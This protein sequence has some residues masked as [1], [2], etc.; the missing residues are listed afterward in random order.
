MD[1]IFT[2]S[3]YRAFIKDAIEEKRSRNPGFSYRCAAN[4]IGISSGSLTRVLNGSRHAGTALL[5]KL[6]PFLGLKKRE[7][8]YFS[9]LVQFES[10]KEETARRLCY[11]EILK[12][13]AERNKPVPDENH[14]FFEQWYHVALF[15]LLRTI[16]DP[17]DY[18]K[19]GSLLQPA[20]SESKTRK[21]LELLE[22]LGYIKKS[23][24]AVM[25]T[26]EP[27]LTTGD[28]WESVAIHGFQVAISELAASALDTVPK[29]ERDFS[30][31]TMA[32]SEDAFTKIRQILQRARSEIAAV[33]KTCTDPERVYQINFQCFPLS[34]KKDHGNESRHADE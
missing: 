17:V 21:A 2:Y 6:I 26:T 16:K 9:L 10:V 3:D 22:R 24:D 15:E 27:F 12:L 4:R 32:L 34:V 25:C 13:R 14:L 8:E 31:L 23:A 19:L 18:S 20:I 7:A 29:R 28:T 11:Q 5:G 33:E 1:S 30:T